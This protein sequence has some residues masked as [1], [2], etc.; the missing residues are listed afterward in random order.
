MDTEV[1]TVLRADFFRVRTGI[2]SGPATS[3]TIAVTGP[4]GSNLDLF[5]GQDNL[6]GSLNPSGYTFSA[7]PT[8][9]VQVTEAEGENEATTVQVE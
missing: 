6:L 9:T 3:I 5:A 1:S 4:D 8:G 2:G 7:N